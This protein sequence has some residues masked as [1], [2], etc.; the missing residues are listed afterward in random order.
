MLLEIHFCT[1]SRVYL[2]H[3]T[4]FGYILYVLKVVFLL[5][6]SPGGLCAVLPHAGQFVP[7]ETLALTEEMGIA[8]V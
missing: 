8:L 4:E 7:G 5:V 2:E 3:R 1:L 6:V